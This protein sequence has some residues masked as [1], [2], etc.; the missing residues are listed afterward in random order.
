MKRSFWIFIALLDK[1]AY[2]ELTMR[3]HQLLEAPISDLTY[4]D[5]TRPGGKNTFDPKDWAQVSKPGLRSRMIKSWGKSKQNFTL[6]FVNITGED[7]DELDWAL[8]SGR[9]K[10]IPSDEKAFFK[11]VSSMVQQKI[12]IKTTPNAINVL[13]LHHLENQDPMTPWIVA[14]RISHGLVQSDSSYLEKMEKLFN[15]SLKTITMGN[16]E[17]FYVFLSKLLPMRSAREHH[18]INQSRQ[19]IYNELFAM[20]IIKGKISFN[21]VTMD[22]IPERAKKFFSNDPNLS[23]FNRMMQMNAAQ[24]NEFL[25]QYLQN[26][27]GKWI[28]AD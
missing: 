26:Y 4:S 20:Y 25:D 9:P 18:L 3:L 16:V 21:T 23:Y 17:D 22:D 2:R 14:H 8:L 7:E 6:H 28:L 10:Q 1:Y 19:E 24:L 5:Q 13:F 27:L 15:Q 12:N 11:T